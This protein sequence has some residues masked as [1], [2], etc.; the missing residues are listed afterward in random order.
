[1]LALQLFRALLEQRKGD[2]GVVLSF[3]KTCDLMLQLPNLLRG[4]V[5]FRGRGLFILLNLLL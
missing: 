4:L 3:A 2:L 5:K 1:L